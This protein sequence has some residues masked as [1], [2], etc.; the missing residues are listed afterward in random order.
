MRGAR[1]VLVVLGL[2]PLGYGAWLLVRT[3][4]SG[5]LREVATWAVAGVL[6][7]DAAIA[8]LAAGLGWLGDRFLPRA[9]SS[10]AAVAFIL[11]G[12]V[13]VV[14]VP[15]LDGHAAGGRN[16]TLLDRDYAGGWLLVVGAVLVATAAGVGGGRVLSVIARTRRR[17]SGG[18][19]PGGR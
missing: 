13:S 12:T 14:A 18:T 8:P 16:H 1:V 19:G 3:Q 2:L 6:L 15:V 11:I 7:H 5:Q 10:A 17:T 4:G 9:A